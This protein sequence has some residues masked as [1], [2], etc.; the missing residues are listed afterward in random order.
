[1]KTAGEVKVPAAAERLITR[2]DTEPFALSFSGQGYPWIEQLASSLASGARTAITAAVAESDEILKPV[3]DELL[4]W[5]PHG[6]KPLEWAADSTVAERLDLSSA[7]M[8]TPGITL[9][10]LALLDNLTAQGLRPDAAVAHIG[11]SQGVLATL[12]STGTLDAGQTIA[13][14]RLIGV[15]VAQASRETG[16]IRTGELGPMVS[17]GGIVTE[18]D[19]EALLQLIDAVCADVADDLKP[20]LALRNSRDAVVLVGRPDD[21][22]KVIAALED[23]VINP[24]NVQCG[25]HHPAMECAV[26]QVMEWARSCGLPE[27]SARLGARAVLSEPVHWPERVEDA[28]ISGARW[29]LELGP[30]GGVAKLTARIVAGLGVGVLDVSTHAGQAQL[31]DAGQAPQAPVNYADFAPKVRSGEALSTTFTELTGHSPIMLAGMTPT[32]VDP[33]IVAAAANAGHWAELAGGGQVTETILNEHLARLG[34]LLNPGVNAQFNAM[35]LSPKQW[36]TQI[37]GKRAVPRARENGAPID[38]IVVSAGMPPF[39]EAVELVKSLRDQNFPWVAFKPGAV[40]HI[41]NVLRVADAIPEIPLIIQVEGGVAGGHH[42]WEDLDD[43]LIATYGDIRR[44][45]NVVLAVGGGIG[46]PER[47]ADY[48]T[49]SWAEEHGLPPMPVDAILVG[50]AAMAAKESTASESVKQALVDTTGLPAEDGW[51]EAGTARSGMASGRSQLGADIHEIDNSFA[52]AGR[53]IDEV[54]GDADAVAARRDE[55]IAAINKTAK[56]YFGDLESM[57]YAQWLRRYAELSFRGDW[58]DLSWAKRLGEMIDRTQARLDAQDHGEFTPAVTFD[59]QPGE[60]NDPAA[61]LDALEQAYPQAADIELY[62]ADI[63]W[64][65]KLLRSPGK[66]AGF[67]PVIDADVRLW[68]RAD[69]LW[70]AHDARFDADEVCI[71]PG[72]VAVAG[73]TE[74]NEPV[75]DILAR[76]EK[77]AVQ[78]LYAVAEQR[79]QLHDD[80]QVTEIAPRTL[81]ERV[82]TAPYVSWAGRYQSNPVQLLDDPQLEVINNDAADAAAE[83]VRL[84]VDM[85]DGACVIDFQLPEGAPYAAVPEVSAASAERA[86][87][88]LVRTAAGGQLAEGEW[89]TDINPALRAQYTNVTAGYVTAAEGEH[90]AATAAPDVLV[91]RAWPAV[92]SAIAQAE[93]PGTGRSVIEGMLDLVHLEHNLTLHQPV[94]EQAQLKVTARATDVRDTLAGRVVEVEA[95]IRAGDT[96]AVENNTG[97]NLLATLVERFAIRGRRGEADVPVTPTPDTVT[98]KAPSFRNLLTVTAPESMRPFAV[99]SGDR[100][101]IHVNTDAAA[102]AGLQDGVIV[103]GMWTSALAQAAAA[104]DGVEIREWSATMAAPILPGATIEY[105]VERT[106]VDTRA[107]FGEVRTVTATVNGELVLTARAIMSAPRTF[108]GF[109]GQGIQHPGMGMDAYTSSAAAREVWDRADRHTRSK[110]GFSILDIV[111]TNPDAVVVDGE[112]FAH[113]DGA[114]FLTQF[115]QVAMATLGCAQVAEMREAGVLEKDAFFAGHSVGEYNALAAF[116]EVLSLEAVVEIVY[117]RGLTMHRLVERDA[118][119]V[120]N[121]GL[122]ALRPN[123]MGVAADEVFNHVAQI[124]AATGEFLEIV[125]Y[126]IYGVQYAVAGTRKGLAALAAD[127][128]N[129]APGKRAFIPIPGIDVP[130][131]SSHLLGGVDDFREHLDSL[132]PADLDYQ[133]LEERYVPN[134]VARPFELTEDF[135]RAIADVVDSSY[136]TDILAD[137]DAALADR[138]KLARVLLIEL[139]AWQFASPVRWIET[140][141]LLLAPQGR[142]AGAGTPGLG[143]GRFVEIGVGSSPTL[144]NML[145]QTLRLPKYAAADL[146]VFNIERDRALAFAEDAAARP[147]T[148]GDAAA[149]NT[150]DTVTD[151]AA[152]PAGAATTAAASETSEAAIAA[153]VPAAPAP[154]PAAGSAPTPEDR[155][156]TAGDAVE[157]LIAQWTKVR[158]DQMGP[159]DTIEQLVEGVSSRRNQLLLDLG[160]EFGLGAIEGAADAELSAL[161]STVAG[162]AKGYKAFGPVLGDAVADSLRRLTGPAGKKPSYVA[163]Y[164]TGT[165]QLGAGWADHATAALVLGT[166]EGASLRGGEL[167]TLEPASPSNAKELDALIDAAIVA[168]GERVGVT[169][170]KPAAGGVAAGGVVDSAALGEFSDKLTGDRGVLAA[171]ARELLAQLG[172]HG[173]ADNDSARAATEAVTAAATANQELAELMDTVSAELGQDWPRQV[174]PSFDATKAVLL[175][176]AWAYARETLSRV[177]L[178]EMDAADV[179]VTGAGAEVAAMAEFLGL[180]QLAEQALDNTALEFTTDVAVVTGGSPNSIASQVIA[181]LLRGG[182][183]VVATTSRLNHGRLD[184]Y[185]NLYAQHA[186]GTAALWV[187]PANLSSYRDVDAL[188]EWIGNEDTATVGGSKK[189]LKPA[190]VPTLLFPFAA[191]RVSGSLADT[192]AQAE[193]QMRLLLWAVEKLIAGLSTLGTSTHVGQRLH[194]VLPGSPNRGTFGGDGAYGESKA[195]LDALVNRWS[196]EPIWGEQTSLVH[197]LIGW[198]RGTGLMGGNDPLVDAVEAKGVRTFSTEEMAANLIGQASHEVRAQAAQ[199]PVVADFTGGLADADVDMAALARDASAAATDTDAANNG[200][201]AGETTPRTLRALPSIGSAVRT[202][203]TDRPTPDFSGTNG[204]AVTQDLDDMIVIVGAGELGPIGTSRTRYEVEMTGDLSA[205]GVIE[206]AW[207]R[208]LITWEGGAGVD[209]TGGWVDADGVDIDEEDIYARYHDDVLAGVGIRRFHDDFGMVD[210]LA[211]ELT[212]IYLEKD[213]TFT[214]ANEEEARAFAAEAEGASVHFNGEDWEVTRPAGSA[215]RVPRRVAMSRFVGGQVPEG[216]DPARYGIPADMV[217]NL[218]RVALWNIVC[219]VEAFLAAGFT[220]AELLASVHPARVSSTQ[221]TGMGGTGS[222]RSLYVDKLVATPRPNDILQEAL[223][224]VVAAH[225]MQDYVGGY[226]QMIHPVAACATAAVSVEEGVDKLRLRKAD[227]VVAGGI[228]DLSLEGITGFGDMAA[229]ADSGDMAAKGIED[230]YFSRANDRRRGGFIEAEGGG[231]ILLARGTLAAELGLPV[232]GVVA[233]AES[234]ADGAHTSIPAPGLGA[235]SA[236]RGGEDSR[237]ALALR[238]VGVAADDVAVLSK[239]DTSTNANDPNESDVHERIAHAIGRSAGNPLYV[240]SQKSITGHAKGGAA[241][242]QL[243]GLTQ[244]LRDAVIPANRSLDCVDPVLRKHEHLVWLR[245]PLDV[246]SRGI[247]AGLLT[248]LGFGH[249]SALVAVVHPGAFI[250]A[251]RTA[252]GEDAVTEWTQRA[253]AR[254][255]DGERRF[256]RALHGGAALF[257]RPADRNLGGSGDAVKEREAAVLLSHDARLRDGLLEPNPEER[258]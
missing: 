196:A 197:A 55:I 159:A 203:G 189:V 1:M 121:Y 175:D 236:A 97:E 242:F 142:T 13:L 43:L 205:A 23:H 169:M 89:T 9:A 178:G 109:P 158:R 117:R 41:H 112:R 5:L 247:K 202:V 72:T 163:E 146:E 136:I 31:F 140:Q 92:F 77:A 35:Y 98:D 157:M 50:T 254:V 80:A 148:D 67:V 147:D 114:L 28:V 223:P 8:S 19:E 3:A 183:T 227:F 73:I 180:P 245:Q 190:Q 116:G 167:A 57:T 21:N 78:R 216:F 83:V 224:N 208:G 233:F 62:P 198:V 253:A 99:V 176:D 194:V 200:A 166:R 91:G 207:N 87:Q 44:R 59:P 27:D 172:R 124:A 161:Q 11:H 96:T 105:L 225:V 14:A 118:N 237:L 10:Q 56:P 199:A 185:K 232:L 240:V 204:P 101:P 135:V 184:Y 58:V 252:R 48:L 45:D 192:G 251:L 246:S 186:R 110:L 113:P 39:E 42:S 36:R 250:E 152:A 257:E 195:S 171:T 248:S 53:L 63:A 4:P 128:E 153:P 90:A 20:V 165:W 219:T 106:G 108:Y 81:L 174:A 244:L 230:K 18:A 173:F 160:V 93:I 239:H 256:A 249:V 15:A 115:T 120:S 119:G 238:E 229:T 211:P 241:A 145:G 12:A 188:V 74:A 88:S 206:L 17:I 46:T 181:E 65:I 66:P 70:Q 64:F 7:E 16:L 231:T 79:A 149:D 182:A 258:S 210:N 34:E 103:H 243:V 40:K 127:A 234:F 134:L 37:E 130:F 179:D 129:H 126:N 71:I 47:A 107:G 226:G 235:L 22:A 54:A 168:A 138:Q 100:N 95:E 51:V 221:G 156:F 84:T 6:F 2:L 220:P 125:N 104:F 68:W 228:D 191:P 201:G 154:A 69:S 222:L 137:F 52:R 170:A 32:T 30:T 193:N 61:A 187:V 38:G 85:G 60:V 144:A 26:D 33:Q 24:L 49:G 255:A 209:G 164:V 155:V 150:G 132:I 102:L 123:K 151:A 29:I 131:H 215:V 86:M 25:Y 139:L 162:M 143:I 217:D 82:R 75:A 214:A 133:V 94:P 76:F 218:D 122:A 141:D 212:T 177:A 111:R 213:L